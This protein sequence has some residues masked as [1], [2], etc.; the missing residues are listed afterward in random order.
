M[1]FYKIVLLGQVIQATKSSSCL[2]FWI[3]KCKQAIQLLENMKILDQKMPA[4]EFEFQIQ[5]FEI[6]NEK[7]QASEFYRNLKLRI[8]KYNQ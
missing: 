2:K 6:H 8:R 4:A 5:N 1:L 7:M 3:R